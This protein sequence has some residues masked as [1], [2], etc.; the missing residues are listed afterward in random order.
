MCLLR[1]A[2]WRNFQEGEKQDGENKGRETLQWWVS[3]KALVC[4]T[5]G[6]WYI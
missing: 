6:L 1:Q 4:S 5:G 3:G 2:L